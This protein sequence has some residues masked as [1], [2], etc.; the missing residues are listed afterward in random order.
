MI[1]NTPWW[2]GDKVNVINF[3][4]EKY[5]YVT[6]ALIFLLSNNILAHIIFVFIT[7]LYIR[8]ARQA[9]INLL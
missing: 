8:Q 3:F 5:I 2:K 6:N 4:I 7:N 1:Y 9:Q